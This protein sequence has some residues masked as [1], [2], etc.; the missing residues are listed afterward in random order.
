MPCCCCC[1]SC[2]ASFEPDVS[3]RAR[4][5]SP[6]SPGQICTGVPKLVS[7]RSRIYRV[8][9][10]NSFFVRRYT[11]TA[12]AYRPK[13]LCILYTRNERIRASPSV[14]R[15]SRPAPVSSTGSDGHRAQDA[16]TM[17]GTALFVP[18]TCLVY[19]SPHPTN[20]QHAV[21]SLVFY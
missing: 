5:I 18:A 17:A 16:A 6:P 15:P 1:F 8:L 12:A 10:C 19:E 20:I 3:A 14:A 13:R 21:V 2:G 11:R 9:Q 4:L 7:F